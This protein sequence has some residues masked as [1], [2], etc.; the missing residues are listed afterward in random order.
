MKQWGSFR[1][2]LRHSTSSHF[3]TPEA[4]SCINSSVQLP[5]VLILAE[6]HVGL[7]EISLIETSAN[8]H[9][10]LCAVSFSFN[11]AFWAISDEQLRASKMR[12][13]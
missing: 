12:S 9:L 7:D 3:L 10:Q 13:S 5:K 11:M 1:A 2:T 6:A 4:M 8:G